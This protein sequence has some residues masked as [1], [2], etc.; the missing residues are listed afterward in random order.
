MHSGTFLLFL[1]FPFLLLSLQSLPF[2]VSFFFLFSLFSLLFLP[3]LPFFLHSVP[4]FSSFSLL[5]CFH[6]HSAPTNSP[7]VCRTV[8]WLF[9]E[10]HIFHVDGKS[11]SNSRVYEIPRRYTPL[12]FATRVLSNLLSARHTFRVLVISPKI[13]SNTS[14]GTICRLPLRSN[15][16]KQ[17]TASSP[18]ENHVREPTFSRNSSSPRLTTPDTSTDRKAG[19]ER[20]RTRKKKKKERR[21]DG[22]R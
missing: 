19:C 15:S 14:A 1:Q 22:R 7:F 4:F 12:C 17:Q 21:K 9:N 13:R 2:F 16:C 5:L 11:G 10:S 3:I 8:S 20:D 6:F 18:S